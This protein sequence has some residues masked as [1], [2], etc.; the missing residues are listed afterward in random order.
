MMLFNSFSFLLFFA[1][2]V[3]VYYVIDHRYRWVLLLA[4]SLYFYATFNLEYVVLLMVSTIVIYFAGVLMGAALTQAKKKALLV[5]GVVL[6]FLPLIVFKYLDFFGESLSL[7]MGRDDPMLPQLNWALPAG[8]SF[9]T[10]SC[11][12]YVVDVYRGQ[13]APER[14]FGRLA[15]YV[16]FFPKLLAGPINRATTFLPQLSRPVSFNPDAVQQG[17]QLI[18][19]GLFK[20]VVIADRLGIYVDAAYKNPEFASP[21]ALLIATYFFAFQIYCDFSGYADIAIGTSRV[22]GIDLMANFRRPYLSTSVTEFWGKDRWHISLSRWFRDYLYIPMGGSKGRT[23]RVYANQMAVF[24]VSGLWHGANW[25]FVIW[26]ALN[27][28]YQILTLLST[29]LRTRLHKLVPLP[30]A[31]GAVLACLLTFHLVLISW[32]FF[33][34]SS[35]ADAVTVLTRLGQ[36]LPQLPSLLGSYA[37]TGELLLC[38]VLILFLLGVEIVDEKK[39]V[40]G[41][42]AVAPVYVRWG[43]YYALLMALLVMGKW[44]LKQFIYMQF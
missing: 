40:W 23:T 22:L 38:A 42:L 13:L 20:K 34:A 3:L 36:T 10:F 43:V 25:T 19:W 29:G 32:V 28:L 31:L 44:N 1:A 6:S 5:G 14:H 39:G 15:L 2:V 4:S 9:Y 18:L 30:P 37:Y 27:G 41:R 33:R 24:L 8:L 11:V 17:L 12:S 16:S 21:V 26:G 7:A 35:V